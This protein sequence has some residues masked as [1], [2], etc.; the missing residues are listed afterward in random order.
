[1]S[2]T[3]LS[4]R[5]LSFAAIGLAAVLAGSTA[6][7]CSASRNSS[8]F[9]SSNNG[10]GGS[11][12]SQH[13]GTGANSGTSTNNGGNGGDVNFT[14]SG[15][16]TQSTGSIGPDGGCAGT[17]TKAQQLPLDIYIMLD[18]SGSM[19]DTVAGGGTKWDAVTA[20]LKT[21]LQQPG[22]G[23]ISVGI[24]YF[25]VPP[26]GGTQSCNCVVDS[27]CMPGDFCDFGI[28]FSCEIAGD[29]CDAA[30]YAKPDVEIAAL[31]GASSA[32]V[33]SINAHSPN[34]STPTSAALQGAVDHAKAWASSHPGDVVIDILAT[35][36]DPTECDIDLGNIDAIAAAGASGTPKVLTFVIGVGSSLGAL[37]G[38]A[39]AGGTGQAFI[40]DTSQ[41]VNMQF[42]AALN[43]IRGTALGCNYSIPV[44]QNG[45]PDFTAVNVQYTPGGGGMPEIIP[46]V[47]DKA[48]CPSSGDAWYYDNALAPMQI[49]LCDSTCNTL[50]KD[51]TGEVDVVLGCKT[52]VK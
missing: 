22:L 24:Q 11:G 28:C 35:D 5:I 51:S 17:A 25:G 15:S 32:L 50:S 29:S 45:T 3:M 9:T 31:P 27:D 14:T 4:S 46:Q 38:I 36:G 23:G 26:G 34:T 43:A 30:D 20:A 39:A 47:A 40:V 1:M 19:L 41:N 10:G 13:S 16:G 18:Q 12:S 49:L 8:G 52:V 48:H 2:R 37:N 7:S 44:P 6:A 42:L 33:N 21:F